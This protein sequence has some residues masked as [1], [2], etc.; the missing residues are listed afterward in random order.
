M[1]LSQLTVAII[2]YRRPHLL[3]KCL[4]SFL[5]QKYLPHKILI[6]D[7]DPKFTALAALKLHPNLPLTIIHSPQNIIAVARNLALNTCHTPYLAFIDDDCLLSPNWLETAKLSIKSHPDASLINGQ[8]LLLNPNHPLAR[9]QF[10]IN[11]NRFQTNPHSSLYQFNNLDIDTKNL[12]LNL[13]KIGKTRF[14]PTFKVSEDTDFGLQLNQ[15]QLS[16]VYQPHLIVYHQETISLF[17]VIK[18]IFKG[19]Y[20]RYLLE[21]KWHQ[22]GSYFPDLNYHLHH[23]PHQSYQ[24]IYDLGYLFSKSFNH[25]FESTPVRDFPKTP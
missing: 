15:R 7:N 12:I 8:S 10:Q 11:Q 1:K 13:H 3:N 2:T 21:K 9:M 24:L 19:G 4:H 25:I 16:G 18:K 20:Y 6:V 23:L 22:V 14:D 5:P 17:P